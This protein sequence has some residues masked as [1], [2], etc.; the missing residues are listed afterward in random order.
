M[1][2]KV[3]M[4]GAGRTALLVE[5]DAGTRETC[6]AAL[7]SVGFAV[8]L[9]D[10][11]VAAVSAA[12]VTNPDVVLFDLELRDVRGS[13]LLH[14]LRSNPALRHAPMIAISALAD[15][16]AAATAN[17]VDGVLRKPVS[18]ALLIEA[19]ETAFQS[20]TRH[21]GWEDIE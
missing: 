19:V 1:K 6:R 11:G 5:A 21:T 20:K 18:Q 9:V 4:R 13:D 2:P 7:E 15:G 10:C 12:R 14:W 16:D 17:R 8:T 3:I